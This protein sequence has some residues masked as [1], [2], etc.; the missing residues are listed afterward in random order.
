MTSASSIR[1]RISFPK[2]AILDGRVETDRVWGWSAPRMQ[3]CPV[4][5]L[6]SLAFAVALD[7]IFIGECSFDPR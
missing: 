2:A 3:R 4:G 7:L 5:T 6:E 1:Y